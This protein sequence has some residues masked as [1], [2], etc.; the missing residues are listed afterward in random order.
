MDSIKL[1][2]GAFDAAVAAADPMN[3]LKP[4]LPALPTKGRL[5]VV[6]AGKAAASMAR[7]VEA[8]YPGDITGLVV[9]RY[10]HG[11]PTRSIE[12]LEAAHPVPD[13][14]G[15]RAAGRILDL[16][17]GLGPD[18]VVLALISG[19]GSALLTLPL[20]GI[21][22]DEIQALYRALLGSGANIGEFNCVRRHLSRTQGGRLA[23]AAAPARV[24]G[25]LMSDVPGDDE[26]AIASGPTVADASTSAQ[27]RAILR[28][29]DIELP[30]SIEQALAS[31]ASESIKPGDRRLAN[32][33]SHV[34]VTPQAS[35]EAAA[36]YIEAAGL[37]V[38][39]LS[40][41]IEGEARDVG[42]AL[43]A[44]AVQIAD[45]GQ[46]FAPPCVVLSGGET[47]VTL[48]ATEKS[49]RGGRNVEFLLAFGLAIQG[50]ANI[51]ALAADTD[52]I[53]GIEEI[54]G[55]VWTPDT[56][57][58]A[59][60]QKIDPRDCLVR[61]DAHS[62]FEKLGDSVVTGPTHTNVNDFRAIF[63]GSSGRPPAR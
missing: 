35:L 63:V 43:G 56:L 31:A 58:A 49:G 57:K 1:L 29:Y 14:A 60:A 61:H 22:L 16:V 32:T 24:I 2:R 55:A 52:G 37:P 18:D 17:S 10:G 3:C 46:P 4:Y 36:R 25:L 47:T 54:A 13:E 12:V 40:D 34:V 21:A 27:A 45:R 8:H 5:V 38:H 15:L 44:I 41:R 19:G 26:A 53:D 42:A 59:A 20:P 11:L 39:V 6:G 33:A 50:H 48:R 7:A 23:A 51:H 62:F 28:H 30:P 9:T